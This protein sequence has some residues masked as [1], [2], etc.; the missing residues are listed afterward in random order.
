MS[1]A[2]LGLRAGEIVRFQRPDRSRWQ[3]GTVR[4]RERDGSIRLV[5]GNGATRAVTVD[6]IEV[7]RD[8]PRGAKE[9]EPLAVRAARAEQLDLLGP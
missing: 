2:Q 4:R 1:L 8:G 3:P 5:D 6:L 7:R 9:W